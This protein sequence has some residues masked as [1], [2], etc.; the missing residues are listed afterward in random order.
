MFLNEMYYKKT[1]GFTDKKGIV[2]LNF[3]SH[4]CWQIRIKT[5]ACGVGLACSTTRKLNRKFSNQ[6]TCKSP[7]R[8]ARLT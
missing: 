3:S 5:I 7:S 6:Q 4:L 8:T 2:N 1:K